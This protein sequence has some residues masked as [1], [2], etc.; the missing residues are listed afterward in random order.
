MPIGV[1]GS[2]REWWGESVRRLEVQKA[3][4][5]PPPQWRVRL[6]PHRGSSAC[7]ARTPP[8]DQVAPHAFI[9]KQNPKSV[10]ALHSKHFTFFIHPLQSGEKSMHVSINSDNYE[11]SSLWIFCTGG[12]RLY[13]S[14]LLTNSYN[15]RVFWVYGIASCVAK[16]KNYFSFVHSRTKKILLIYTI[17]TILFLPTITQTRISFL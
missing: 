12:T 4:S 1:L 14:C 17:H 13:P 6:N 11:V 2:P 8:P 9:Y 15:R 3:M 16:D 5:F 10:T 7:Q